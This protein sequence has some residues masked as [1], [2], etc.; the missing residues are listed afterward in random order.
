MT[1]DKAVLLLHSTYA[2]N[3]INSSTD[4]TERILISFLKKRVA[5]IMLI[6]AINWRVNVYH[7]PHFSVLAPLYNRN[8]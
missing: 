6:I 2:Q 1:S 8:I 4:A 7:V 5:L 3:N